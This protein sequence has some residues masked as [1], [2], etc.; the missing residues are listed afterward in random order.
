[1]TSGVSDGAGE[2]LQ[3]YGIDEGMLPELLWS[4]T[5]VGTVLPEVARELGLRPDC[6]VAVGAQDQ[7][8]AALGVGLQRG[9]IAVSLGDGGRGHK[10]LDNASDGA[11][12]SS[13]L[14]WLRP[15]QYLGDG[16]CRQHGGDLPAVGAGFD[17]P[18]GRLRRHQP[19]S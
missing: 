5:P 2:L 11:A 8:C 18:G 3:R 4:G 14:V 13:G 12:W 10:A 7:K 15:S 16:G 19:G 9:T 6:V 17:V 1:M